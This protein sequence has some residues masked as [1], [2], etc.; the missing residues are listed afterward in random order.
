[1]IKGTIFGS[2]AR[3]KLKTGVDTLANAVKV[4]LG[5]QGRNVIIDKN[6]ITPHIT[7]DGV[8]VAS[9]ITLEDRIE[10]IACS[11]LKDIAKKTADEAGDGTTT[12]TV[13]A[14]AI[15]DEG[16]K[17]LVNT[18]SIELKTGMNLALYDVVR[19]IKN[20][21][22]SIST[23]QE[24][25]HVAMISANNDVEIAS[26]VAD[27]FERIGKNGIIQVNKNNDENV[28][29]YDFSKGMKYDCGYIDQ[30][31]A[32]DLEKQ[33]S[34]LINPLV[35]ITN[36]K[37]THF[38]P[39]MPFAKVA[40]E[41][42]RPLLIIAD[43]ITGH[44]KAALIANYK[45]NN[46]KVCAVFP[47]GI[48][49]QRKELLED[50]ACITKTTIV[51]DAYGYPFHR[52]ADKAKL[53]LGSCGQVVVTRSNTTFID[54]VISE[55]D[56]NKRI[57][58]IESHKDLN[59]KHKLIQAKFDK[60]IATLKEN[61]ATLNVG[62][63]TELEVKEKKDRYDDAICAV[64]AALEEGVVP[65]GGFSYLAVAKFL[66]NSKPE[67]KNSHQEKG[68]NIVL[69]AIKVPFKQIADN[70]GVDYSFI[71][72]LVDYDFENNKGYD[73]RN[74]QVVDDMIKYGIVDPAKVTRIAIENA[75]S[76][77]GLMLTTEAIVFNKLNENDLANIQRG[78]DV[79]GKTFE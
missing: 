68:Y 7:K 1:M 51:G 5:P 78:K 74:R 79:A 3:L 67:F 20:K 45:E 14:Q 12:A 48:A 39:L 71:E 55:E 73:F 16:L 22:E 75:V 56:L 27:I 76:I 58:E 53:F 11:M 65:G 52:A 26:R 6:F 13:L 35:F 41:Q 31:F 47:P 37:L 15:F 69:E 77:A 54:P 32:T 30:I 21:A 64:R 50:I 9:E 49:N 8:T 44:A 66:E 17:Q 57:A 59:D 60:R 19:M 46:L 70:C 28:T 18:N 43:E 4:T 36:E 33:E 25:E 42:K 34:I 40:V 61:V 62:G 24:L 2:E 38:E 10:N 63:F 23:R 72:G 29:S